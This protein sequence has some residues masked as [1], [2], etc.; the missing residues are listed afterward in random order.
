MGVLKF[1]QYKGPHHHHLTSPTWEVLGRWTLSRLT[2]HL[3]FEV[4]CLVVGRGQPTSPF[5]QET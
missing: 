5:R 3:L 4:L 2:F 1:L